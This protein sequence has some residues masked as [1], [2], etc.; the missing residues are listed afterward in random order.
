[1]VSASVS[2]FLHRIGTLLLVSSVWNVSFKKSVIL[3][4]QYKVEPHHNGPCLRRNPVYER[5]FVLSQIAFIRNFVPE[6][7]EN[8]C[9]K[10]KLRVVDPK[11]FRY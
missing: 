11:Q 8:L 10:I 9:I 3:E 2:S 6:F 7:D 4:W 5:H 1:M